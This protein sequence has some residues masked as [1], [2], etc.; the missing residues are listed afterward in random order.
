M[1]LINYKNIDQCS[2]EEMEQNFFH[3]FNNGLN[4]NLFLNYIKNNNSDLIQV[5]NED[6]TVNNQY[7][8]GSREYRK[9]VD[10]FIKKHDNGPIKIFRQDGLLNL[11]LYD[12]K[13]QNDKVKEIEDFNKEVI[14]LYNN[15]ENNLLRAVPP[16]ITTIH[17][18]EPGFNI[19]KEDG[20][21]IKY[22]AGCSKFGIINCG[23]KNLHSVLGKLKRLALN[24]TT[25]G[26]S[27]A[28]AINLKHY[29]A[30]DKLFNNIS[31]YAR[32]SVILDSYDNLLTAVSMMQLEF[33]GLPKIND[34]NH[35]KKT[36]YEA[37]HINTRIGTVNTEIQFHTEIDMRFKFI[38]DIIYHTDLYSSLDERTV[39]GIEMCDTKKY[40]DACAKVIFARGTFQQNVPALDEFINDCSKKGFIRTQPPT[41]KNIGIYIRNAYAAQNDLVTRTATLLPMIENINASKNNQHL[42]INPDKKYDDG[43]M[44]K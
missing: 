29:Q 34:F 39:E 3:I 18:N 20:Y 6:G 14:T 36:R 41:E 27:M 32:I 35:T 28:E 38:D 21:E 9:Y 1:D 24:N 40:A 44:Q 11:K 10:A 22:P 5:L 31:D 7:K 37:V 16:H 26:L 13:T 17:A 23:Q 25:S 19:N 33:G 2:I 43:G 42:G 12:S 8:Y 15:L 30:E 4:R